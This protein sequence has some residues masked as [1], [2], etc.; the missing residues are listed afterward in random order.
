MFPRP[1]CARPSRPSDARA[2]ARHRSPRGDRRRRAVRARR[3]IEREAPGQPVGVAGVDGE[4]PG[5]RGVERRFAEAEGAD[6]FG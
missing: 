4:A 2:I 1:P 5:E 6:V 3:E